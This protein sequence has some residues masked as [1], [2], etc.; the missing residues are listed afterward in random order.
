LE[1]IPYVLFPFFPFSF[2]LF[3]FSFVWVADYH[4]TPVSTSAIMG[5]TLQRQSVRCSR[6]LG[7]KTG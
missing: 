2:F 3:P 5:H 4:L 7:F 6:S 1:L